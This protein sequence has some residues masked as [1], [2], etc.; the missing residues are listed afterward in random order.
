MTRARIDTTAKY[1]SSAAYC[2]AAEGDTLALQ[3]DSQG[4]RSVT[5]P[6]EDKRVIDETKTHIGGNTCGM[7]K[8]CHTNMQEVTMQE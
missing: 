3:L 4:P 5:E 6:V 2:L 8:H 1:S 7:H